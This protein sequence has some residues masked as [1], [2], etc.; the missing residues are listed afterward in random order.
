M[1]ECVPLEGQSG[2]GLVS[3]PDYQ[4]P[5]QRFFRP[6]T[7][8]MSSLLD[9]YQLESLAGSKCSLTDPRYWDDDAQLVANLL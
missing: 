6:R 7:Q 3:G 8:R 1:N 9:R 2:T 4:L 5:D